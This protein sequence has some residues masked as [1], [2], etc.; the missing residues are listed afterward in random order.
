MVTLYYIISLPTPLGCC[1]VTSCIPR[2]FHMATKERAGRAERLSL[3][4]G[5]HVAAPFCCVILGSSYNM[6]ESFFF[7]F[8][9]S[10]GLGG[11]G[12]G[13]LP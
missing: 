3:G 6:G 1:I 8:S 11:F 5:G 10:T 2:A 4:Y 9:G 13:M 12:K 7:G